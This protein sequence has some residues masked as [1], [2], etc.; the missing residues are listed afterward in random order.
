VCTVEDG[1]LLVL[2]SILHLTMEATWA[3]PQ[4]VIL[5][6]CLTAN[7]CYGKHNGGDQGTWIWEEC[8]LLEGECITNDLDVGGAP[9][10][11]SQ[12]FNN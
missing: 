10:V 7:P 6:G 12:L 9:L 3:R 2:D 5:S 11:L 4:A 1:M 8:N